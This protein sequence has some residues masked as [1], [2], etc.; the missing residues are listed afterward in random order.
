M[1]MF[2]SS[3]LDC[4]RLLDGPIFFMKGYFALYSK[5]S[6]IGNACCRSCLFSSY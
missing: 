4:F 6:L 5:Y 1:S 3:Q 2:D